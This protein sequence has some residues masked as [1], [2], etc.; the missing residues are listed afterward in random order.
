MKVIIVG[1]VAGGATR[2]FCRKGSKL[3]PYQKG[4]FHWRTVTCLSLTSNENNT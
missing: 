2:M 3:R 4:C 1:G